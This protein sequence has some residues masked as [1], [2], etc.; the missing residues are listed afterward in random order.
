MEGYGL[1]DFNIYLF[2]VNTFVNFR[3]LVD[4]SHTRC[5]KS[6]VRMEEKDNKKKVGIITYIRLA[7]NRDGFAGFEY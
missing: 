6:A 3:Y 2:I 1:E 4:L 5:R 7:G